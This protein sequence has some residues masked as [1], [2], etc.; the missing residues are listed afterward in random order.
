MGTILVSST[1]DRAQVDPSQDAP[2]ASK[3]L[4]DELH[5][6]DWS[7]P[8]EVREAYAYDDEELRVFRGIDADSFL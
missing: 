7:N 3:S 8:K 4:I 5:P 2:D 6:E 1:D